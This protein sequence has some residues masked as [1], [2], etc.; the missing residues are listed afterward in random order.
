VKFLLVLLLFTTTSLPQYFNNL[1]GIEDQADNTHL[2]YRKLIENEANNIYHLDVNSNIEKL[3]LEEK[4]AGSEKIIINDYEFIEKDPSKYIYSETKINTDTITQI[5]KYNG[6]VLFTHS[7]NGGN[8]EISKQDTN[9][10]YAELDGSVFKTTNGG[11]SWTSIF[12]GQLSSVSPFNHNIVFGYKNSLLSK[13]MDG[14]TNFFTVMENT[15]P[16]ILNNFF[17]DKDSLHVYRLSFQD[18]D[19]IVYS[20]LNIS[21]NSGN[22]YS[23][24]SWSE[25]FHFDTDYIRMIN[26]PAV[27]GKLYFVRNPRYINDNIFS[28]YV[29]NSFGTQLS[30]FNSL[31]YYINSIYAKPGTD[32]VYAAVSR[33]IYSVTTTSK[34]IVR[35]LDVNPDVFA[36]YPLKE[37]MKWIYQRYIF[38]W[39]PPFYSDTHYY[40]TE[41]FD[42]TLMSDGFTYKKIKNN[43]YDYEG[44]YY[45]RIDSSEG[46]VRE[47]YD[48]T[49]HVI[50][51]LAMAPGEKYY[52]T[53]YK[54]FTEA[55]KWG[56]KRKVKKYYDDAVDNAKEYF[57]TEGIGLDTVYHYFH[58]GWAV[59]SLQG[60]IMDGIVYGDT[61]LV[62]VE[63]AVVHPSDF[64][65]YQ[66][67]PNPFNPATK[68]KF[69]LP[70]RNFITLKIYDILGKQVA[71]LL[72]EEKDMGDH[73]VL[74]N[75]SNLSSGIYFYTIT[76]DRIQ[77]T[78]KMILIK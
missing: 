29:S 52:P 63:D 48:D 12:S 18:R 67:Y 24:S 14:G 10:I 66:N 13:S 9:V 22:P 42:D 76:R 8:L 26:D 57:F 11:G 62:N 41:V 2:F 43:A 59:T 51:N 16:D 20:H 38:D 60:M 61:T 73:E 25:W 70:Q 45:Q 50:F 3:L 37:G 23:W 36:F 4:I 34:N 44:F 78:R 68:I 65:L 46:T 1:R 56:E 5:K 71:L 40:S 31:G 7:G 53:E 75:A 69:Y 64:T 39:G 6:E 17:Y 72:N 58:N 35:Q 54:G 30:L 77:E 74:F 33:R 21:D 47:Y 28:V 32:Q 15:L 49:S 19:D 27:L 55:D